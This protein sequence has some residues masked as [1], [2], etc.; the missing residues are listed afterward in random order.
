MSRFYTLEE[1]KPI[2]NKMFLFLSNGQLYFG[3][4]HKHKPD[5][6]YCGDDEDCVNCSKNLYYYKLYFNI[7][8]PKYFSEEEILEANSI[9]QRIIDGW[10]YYPSTKN[11]IAEIEDTFSCEV[12]KD[13]ES[14]I[15]GSDPEGGF[16]DYWKRN[17]RSVSY[18]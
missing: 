5:W 14:S 3:E 17:H 15:A 6:F 4:R 8:L 10:F 16:K 1:K 12:S 11:I 2:K 13:Q 18:M 7:K 9:G